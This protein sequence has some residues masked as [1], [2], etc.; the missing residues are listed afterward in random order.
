MGDQLGEEEF[1]APEPPPEPGQ[2]TV[3]GYWDGDI[4]HV[5]GVVKGVH[6]VSGGDGISEEGPFAVCVH[7]VDAET[8]EHEVQGTGEDVDFD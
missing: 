3:I 7:A 1:F 2:F 4:R 6:D 5:V 8:A